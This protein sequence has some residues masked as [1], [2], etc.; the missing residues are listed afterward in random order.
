M[1]KNIVICSDG[2]GNTAI[3]G[4][5]TNVFKLFEAI[6]VNGHKTRPHLTPQ[7]ALYDDGVG[8]EAVKPLKIFAGATGWGLSRNVRQLYK[9]LVRIYDPGDR[10]FLFGFSRG[11]FTVRTLVGLIAA[12][13][14]LDFKRLPTTAALDAMVKKTYRVY[15]TS[16]R[17]ELA[18]LI[19]G[20]PDAS[21]ITAFKSEHCH[22][23]DIEITFMGVWDT[24]D[25][26]GLPFHLSDVINT[27]IYRFKF[28]DHKLS[29]LVKHACHALAIDDERH[30][31]HPLLW[32]ENDEPPGRIEQV[33]FAGAHSNVGGGY[34]KQGMSLVALDWMMRKAE[35]TGGQGK[36][37]RMLA[38]DQKLYRDRANVDDKLYDPRSGLGIFYR[39]KMR[40]IAELCRTH[41][42]T[43][44]AIHLSVLERIAHGTDDYAPGNL[45]S[46]ASVVV[47]PA[48]NSG[49]QS[50]VQARA[51]KVHEMLHSAHAGHASLLSRVRSEISIGL[52]SYY[53]YV[54]TFVFLLVA[55]ST[56]DGLQSFFDPWA[57]LKNMTRL[58]YH[59]VTFEFTD[60]W[61][62]IVLALS[63]AEAGV[64]V[65]GFLLACLLMINADRRMSTVFSQ[66][67]HRHHTQL[68]DALK[69]ARRIA[70]DS[71]SA[72]ETMV[73]A[74]VGN[75]TERTPASST[76]D[77]A[78]ERP[79]EFADIV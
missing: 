30:S 36:G 23:C 47:T 52:A 5:G 9:E 57:V 18:K 61:N 72:K 53:L 62:S 63:P 48:D 41:H 66:F 17:T 29:T 70:R 50:A 32:D 33:W 13:G 38:V 15:R 76:E 24:V 68:R 58:M 37:L 1:P 22:P 16:Y 28:R 42:V 54:S 69:D 34:P 56:P 79:K 10:I 11:A 55:A 45:P 60:V 8:T 21:A 4:R 74:Y 75:N 12:C 73:I 27:A 67:W 51:D 78:H 20:E 46:E 59:L 25:A 2:T 71:A 39:W 19:L 31:F 40:D 49:E 26:V 35:G 44:P 65:V 7:V 14:I 64:V 6:D 43:R 3:K 77:A